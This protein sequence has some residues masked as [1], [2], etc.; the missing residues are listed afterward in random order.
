MAP[1]Q[2][3]FDLGG[4]FTKL[5]GCFDIA[6]RNTLPQQQL[7][8]STLGDGRMLQ[9][10][11]RTPSVA[12]PPSKWPFNLNC[13]LQRGPI[14]GKASRARSTGKSFEGRRPQGCFA[15]GSPP[16]FTHC[17]GMWSTGLW[18]GWRAAP[19]MGAEMQYRWQREW[20]WHR[21]V[22]P[23]LETSKMRFTVLARPLLGGNTCSSSFRNGLLLSTSVQ[24]SDFCS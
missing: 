16:P 13:S 14:K 7:P 1:V 4:C 5:R 8:H 21:I 11:L 9:I 22:S 10:G 17:A 20:Q 24:G 18:V 23:G 12:Q 19:E 6:S 3:W 2:S 15:E